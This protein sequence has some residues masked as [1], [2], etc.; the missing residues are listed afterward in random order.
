MVDAERLLALLDRLE[1]TEDEL[2]RL[3]ELG[4]AAVRDDVDRMYACKYLFVL[5]A[6]I[7]IDAGQH[8][9]A[10]EGYSAPSS[11]AGVFE[12]LARRGAID[13]ELGD[14]LGAMARFRNLLVHGYAEVDDDRVVDILHGDRL[15]DLQ[16]LRSSLAGLAEN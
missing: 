10:S 12:E 9:I 8:V 1:R 4:P 6:E 14:S 16:R 11:F 5:A 3:R 13:A 15:H 7:A 2:R